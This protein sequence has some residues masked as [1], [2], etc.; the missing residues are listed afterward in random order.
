VGRL[1]HTIQS[2]AKNSARFQ[3][4]VR[5]AAKALAYDLTQVS[6]RAYR[7]PCA[8][9]IYGLNPSSLD[10]VEISAGE[11]TDWRELG[12]RSYCT[13][14]W[15]DFDLCAEP[16]NPT[17]L[18]RFDLVIADQVFEHLFWPYRGG[19]NVYRLLKPGGHALLMTPFLIRVHGSP[20]DCSR[21]TEKGMQYFLAECGLPIEEVRTWSWGNRDTVR[22][23]LDTWPRMGWARDMPN[24]RQCP[25]VGWA[26]ARRAK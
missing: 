20:Q 9:L 23:A 13:L 24:E 7:E 18:G 3:S 2:R 14:E 1:K 6:R 4:I 21:W 17:L 22:P 12:C 16:L 25:I 19:R 11:N 15:P 5:I 26:L 10:A 8:D